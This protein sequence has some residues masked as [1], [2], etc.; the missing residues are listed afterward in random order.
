MAANIN[1]I[2]EVLKEAQK[3]WFWLRTLPEYKNDYRLQQEDIKKGLLCLFEV[4]KEDF[5]KKNKQKNTLRFFREGLNPIT[6]KQL[7][8]QEYIKEKW[9]FYPLENPAKKYRP[10]QLAENFEGKYS[11]KAIKLLNFD[12]ISLSLHQENFKTLRFKKPVLPDVLRMEIDYKMSNADIFY[13]IKSVVE[14]VRKEYGIEV[15]KPHVGLLADEY[16][17][18]ISKK[19]DKK[20]SFIFAQNVKSMESSRKKAQ[21][22]LKKINER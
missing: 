10:S 14:L 18:L 12:F 5:A 8:F 4:R 3:A 15:K 16:K 19:L 9:G 22:L 7:G 13:E 21:R 20:D 2:K 1:K 6:K 11:T 17:V